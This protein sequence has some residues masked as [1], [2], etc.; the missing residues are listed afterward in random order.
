MDRKVYDVTAFRSMHPGGEELLLSHAGRDATAAA[1]AGHAGSRKAMSLM[2]KY[3]VG[4]VALEVPKMKVVSLEDMANGYEKPEMV[5]LE[6]LGE[7]EPKKT[8]A[9]EDL[10]KEE[11][12]K[13]NNVALE[14]LGRAG[15]VS[16]EDLGQLKQTLA[17][18]SRGTR[19]GR[20][21]KEEKEEEEQP[22]QV[23]EEEEEEVD[24]EEDQR[25]AHVRILLSSWAVANKQEES[26]LTLPQEVDAGHESESSEEP[27]K[28]SKEMPRRSR[29]RKLTLPKMNL[30]SIEWNKLGSTEKLKEKDKEKE[31]DEKE[32]EKGRTIANDEDTPEKEE[33]VQA[34]LGRDA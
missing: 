7:V 22:T 14:D 17:V 27:V 5:A 23:E 10:G 8:V 29:F 34:L 28:S 11:V 13:S 20:T 32:K 33:S 12:K 2:S 26:T 21:R 19:T 18:P 3:F 25:R 9:L 1:N 6:R 16:L 30:R 15:D 4:H 24:P 31:K